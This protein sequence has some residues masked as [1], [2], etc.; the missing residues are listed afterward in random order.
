MFR[1]LLP[2]ALLASLSLVSACTASQE[3]P[4]QTIRIGYLRLANSQLVSKALG[5]HESAGLKVEWVPFETGGQVNAAIA[6]G[7]IDFGAV[8]TPPAAAGIS[9]GLSYRGLFIL[10]MLGNVE[11]LVVRDDLPISSPADL[12]GKRIAVPFGSTSYYLLLSLLRLEDIPE[13][14]IMLIDMTPSQARAAW[15]RQEIDGAW[16]WETA[17]HHMVTNGGQVL[18]DNADMAKRGLPVGDMAVVTKDLLETQPELVARY[19]QTECAAIEYWHNRPDDTAAIVARELGVEPADAVRMMAGTPVVPC[20]QQLEQSYL[21][22]AENP[23]AVIRSLQPI[24][25]FLF[26]D[27]RIE[28]VLPEEDYDNFV[29]VQPLTE[30]SNFMNSRP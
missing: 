26:E 17:L 2:I 18:I 14:T 10:N 11:G 25:T 13:S 19:V 5:F 3:T 15:D 29:D 24:A 8:G 6:N 16:L 27:G 12:A 28:Q 30:I 22:G 21:G 9:S 1:W 7:Q 20:G 23:G 4:Q